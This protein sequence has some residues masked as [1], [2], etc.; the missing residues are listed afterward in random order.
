MA[1]NIGPRP[2]RADPSSLKLFYLIPSLLPLWFTLPL[3]FLG[4]WYGLVDAAAANASR[5][6]GHAGGRLAVLIRIRE[7]TAKSGSTLYTEGRER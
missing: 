5:G 2:T 4:V 7:R 3:P 1:K 6:D